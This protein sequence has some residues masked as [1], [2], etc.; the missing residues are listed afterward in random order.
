MEIV[1][2]GGVWLFSL[3]SVFLRKFTKIAPM[4]VVIALSI[5]FAFIPLLNTPM[6]T[7]V[8]QR[9]FTRPDLISPTF[10]RGYDAF[11][12][13]WS[14]TGIDYWL[15]RWILGVLGLA[16]Y[17]CALWKFGIKQNIFW[18]LYP[19]VPFIED[20]IQL[21]NYLMISLMVLAISFMTKK[22]T[23]IIVIIIGYWATTM[24]SSGWLMIPGFIAFAVWEIKAI[25]RALVWLYLLLFVLMLIP[26]VRTA[27]ST[28]LMQFNFDLLLGDAGDKALKYVSRNSLNRIVFADAFFAILNFVFFIKGYEFLDRHELITSKKDLI[29]VRILGSFTMVGLAVLPLLPLAYNFDRLVKNSFIF[30]FMFQA[31]FLSKVQQKHTKGHLIMMLVSLIYVLGYGTAYYFLAANDRWILEVVPIFTQNT[32]IDYLRGII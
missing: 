20:A 7:E 19:I 4:L 10:E 26:F 32:F 23:Y 18:C 22:S 17:S 15:Y 27:A 30:F 24:Q 2:F 21:R 28:L 31:F 6:D 14:G 16:C 9:Y 25:R 1:I 12:R 3:L 29:V 5:L 8:Y 11:Q 13:F